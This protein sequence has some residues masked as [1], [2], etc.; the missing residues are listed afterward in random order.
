M[1]L[2]LR[3]LHLAGNRKL[4]ETLGSVLSIENLKAHPH[5]DTLPPTSLT[6]SNKATPPKSATPCE[7]MA[8]NDI[9]ATTTATILILS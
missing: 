9:Q 8:A 1:M 5:S 3:V 6:Y 7:I 2:E 4:T